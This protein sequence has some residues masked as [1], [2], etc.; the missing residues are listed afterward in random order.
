MNL[1]INWPEDDGG[2]S[3]VHNRGGRLTWWHMPGE[4]GDPADE[5]THTQS[6]SDFF[7]NGPALPAPDGVVDRVWAFLGRRRG[8]RDAS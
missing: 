3:G 8:S 4:R 6:V 5:V 7:A 2:L 1:D